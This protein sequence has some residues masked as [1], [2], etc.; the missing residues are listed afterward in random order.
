VSEIEQ[1]T[2]RTR[3]VRHALF[4]PIDRPPYFETLGF[5]PTAVQRWYGEGL[6]RHVRH[7]RDRDD[8]KPGQVTVEEFFDLEGYRWSS[9]QGSPTL[10]P[11]WPSLQREV[12]DENDEI[13]IFRDESGVVKKDLKK[14]RTMPTFL[15]FPVKRRADWEKLRSRLD[16]TVS[17]RYQS[18][19]EAAAD[20]FNERDYLAPYVICG[21][22]GMPRN[23]FGE[24]NLAYIYYDDPK[25][26]HDIMETWLAFYC[27]HARRMC[28]I[29]DFD[30]VFLWEDLAYKNGPLI[31]PDLAREFMFPYLQ[32]L[33]QELRAVGFTV[34]AL[35]T[36]GNAKVL[37]DDFVD[38]G[39]NHVEPCEIAADMEPQWVRQRYG[40]R[41]AIQGG[42]DKRA[43]ATGKSAIDAEVM[44][45]VPELLA[46]GGY[47]PGVDHA[48]P[49]D[50]SFENFC[51][52]LDLVRRLGREIQPAS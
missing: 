18:A 27:E 43:L 45:K 17:E 11:F 32:T 5:W 35:D 42:I 15:E 13:I 34:F 23:L 25:L 48:V 46:Q 51:Y 16:P 40:R 28:G 24:E 7:L 4:E 30:Y 49:S 8:F 6:P 41:C 50:V 31:S 52:F 29:V 19:H 37:M 20:G 10:T 39:V 21:A 26:L 44:R 2:A 1:L 47:C 12:L 9:F 38:A 22:Y 14:S 3:F 33:I 36:D